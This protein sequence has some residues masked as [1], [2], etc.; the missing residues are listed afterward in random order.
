[1][2]PEQA[3][4]LLPVLVHVQAH[5]DGDL[6]LETLASHAGCSAR[7][8]HRLFQ[9]SLRETP[10]KYVE[11]L[12]LERAAF[13]LRF[14]TDSVLHVALAVGFQAHEVFTRAFRRHFR[15]TPRE[16]RQRATQTPEGESGT[17]RQ[18]S[19]SAQGLSD[20]RVVEL[21]P[22]H[23]A[24]LRHVG[25]YEQVDPTC[26]AEI[27]TWLRARRIASHG[28]LLGLGHDAPGITPPEKLRFDACVA[29]GAPFE[30]EGRIACQRLPG[31]PHARVT[32]VGPLDGLPAAYAH[33]ASKIA[34]LRGYRPVWLPILETYH[35][36]RLDDVHTLIQTDIHI[37]L[38]PLVG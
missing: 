6:S 28:W 38:E 8:L 7:H 15:Q 34:D 20:V 3:K 18:P 13:C 22:Q 33:V 21:A 31:G 24:F 1:M 25:P 10:Q 32:H 19:S 26:W 30:G 29:V 14:Q 35:A 27:A 16:Y 36:H 4:R 37:P 2:S 11:R 9:E 12:R 23:V 17:R 5:L